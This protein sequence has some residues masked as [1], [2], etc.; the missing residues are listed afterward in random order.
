[1]T[2]AEARA[3]LVGHLD[4]LLEAAAADFTHRLRA[5]HAPARDFEAVSAALFVARMEAL[6][7]IDRLI[8][9]AQQVH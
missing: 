1:M 9:A 2:A 6:L 8:A 3:V 5:V 7:L 4:A